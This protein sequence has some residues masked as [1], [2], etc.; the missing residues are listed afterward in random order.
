MTGRSLAWLLQALN[1]ATVSSIETHF[2]ICKGNHYFSIR[3][4][5][6][7]WVVW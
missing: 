5:F 4:I 2:I 3:P 1:V 6:S 7:G